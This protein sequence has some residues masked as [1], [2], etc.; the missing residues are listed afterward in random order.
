MPGP[1]RLVRRL[2]ALA[3]R[4]S[5]DTE[6]DEEMRFH[7]EQET[8]KNEREGMPPEE[9]RRAAL[10]AFG[11]VERHKEGVRDAL[12][13]RWLDSLLADLRY[14]FRGLR[15]SPAFTATVII[16]LA[17]GLGANAAMFGIVDRLLFRPPP[18]LRDPPRTHR[19]YYT[20]LD[21]GKPFTGS[22]GPYARYA[23][24]E[25]WTHSFSHM[26]AFT[27]QRLAVGSGEAALEM[28]VAAVSADFFAFF[29]APP[30]AGRYFGSTEDQPPAGSPVAVL[31]W[32]YW[33]TRYGGR[34]DALGSR[35]QVGPVSYTIV[36]VAP[37]GFVGLWPEDPPVLY[38]PITSYAFGQARGP[39]IM[40]EDWW[41]TYHWSW[42]QVI[43]QRR[44]GVSLAAADADLTRAL[45]E[46]YRAQR[47]TSQ[48]R[49][50]VEAARP[51]ATAGSIFAE[52]GP[53]ASSVG[54]V[55][56]WVGGVALI[57]L[58][59]AC[60]NVANLLLAR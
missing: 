42:P 29:K 2:R 26:A 6:L 55:A 14:A 5:V 59:V 22:A 18:M 36:G 25:R 3:R 60:A 15:R 45:T 40:G 20:F 17:L 47:V 49:P 12:T 39:R 43:L 10:L 27:Q 24:L 8:A 51:R 50:P 33:Q 58:V 9:A 7:L 41:T 4:P 44:P 35:L 48:A 37:R 38:L 53:D 13:V 19:F 46:S 11:G 16:T 23:D 28:S 21:H 57:V 1:S 32:A 30:A 54:K 52:R 31:S 34:G 56:T